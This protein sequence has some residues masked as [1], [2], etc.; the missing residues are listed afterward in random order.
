MEYEKEVS[1]LQVAVGPVV[2][3]NFAYSNTGYGFTGTIRLP[4]NKDS[5]LQFSIATYQ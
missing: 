3:R 5:K 4:L 1:R 2:N